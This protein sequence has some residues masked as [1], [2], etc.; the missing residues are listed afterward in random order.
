[1]QQLLLN[2]STQH[3]AVTASLGPKTTADIYAPHDSHPDKARIDQIR[4]ELELYNSALCPVTDLGKGVKQYSLT[5]LCRMPPAS[6]CN[7]FQEP[8]HG[9]ENR[10]ALLGS[11]AISSECLIPTLVMLRARLERVSDT[12]A[13]DK[14]M[15]HYRWIFYLFLSFVAGGKIAGSTL[16]VIEFNRRK[17]VD[18]RRTLRFFR[19]IG[20]QIWRCIRFAVI[21]IRWIFRLL[22]RVSNLVW[23]VAWRM[24]GGILG[25]VSKNDG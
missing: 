3:A 6:F 7:A 8:L 13:K 12:V 18:F 1:V 19:Q 10:D 9:K 23:L 14:Y 16:K 24:Y 5:A 20:N 21:L 4:T 11:N 17:E 22:T 25:R 2:Y 15:K